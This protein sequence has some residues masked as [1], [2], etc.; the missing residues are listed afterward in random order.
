MKTQLLFNESYLSIEY[1]SKTNCL[2]AIWHAEQTFDTLKLGYSKIHELL[3]AKKCRKVLNDNSQVKGDWLEA[4]QWDGKV[5]ISQFID[6]GLTSIAW[7]YP[8]DFYKS[9]T[10][11]H[12]LKQNSE[13]PVYSFGDFNEAEEWI[14]AVA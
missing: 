11:E 7:V 12:A 10:R 9:Y 3:L 2:L 14:Q 1:N 4:A 13:Y 8:T 6:A 5:W